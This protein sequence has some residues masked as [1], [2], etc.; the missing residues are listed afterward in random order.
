MNDDE[1]ELLDYEEQDDDSVFVMLKKP[2]KRKLHI[3]NKT[4]RSKKFILK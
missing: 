1:L 3:V 2:V 4:S